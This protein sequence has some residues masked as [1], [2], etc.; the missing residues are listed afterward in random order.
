MTRTSP[1]T[2][3]ILAALALLALAASPAFAWGT[4]RISTPLTDAV[5]QEADVDERGDDLYE[6]QE[7]AHDGVTDTTGVEVPHEYIDVCFGDE[8]LHVDPPRLSN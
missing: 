8:C 5:A 7:G 1:R 3:R 6:A 2:H 4:L